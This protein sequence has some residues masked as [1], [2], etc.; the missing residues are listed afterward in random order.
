[1]PGPPTPTVTQPP[2]TPPNLADAPV[3]DASLAEPA[4]PRLGDLRPWQPSDDD[5]LPERPARGFR[6]RR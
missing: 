4:L 5:I 3:A 2:L 1:M 6:L